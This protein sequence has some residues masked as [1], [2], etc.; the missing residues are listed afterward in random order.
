MNLIKKRLPLK[1]K[2]LKRTKRERTKE[3]RNATTTTTTTNN[4]NYLELA[5]QQMHGISYD[6]LLELQAETGL[7]I[8]QLEFMYYNL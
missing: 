4:L 6:E 3:M 7:S 5:Y 8:G 1:Q 2:E